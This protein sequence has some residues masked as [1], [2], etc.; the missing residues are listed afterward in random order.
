VAIATN[1]LL[2]YRLPSALASPDAAH[3]GKRLSGFVQHHL[4]H[5]AA[6]GGQ[7]LADVI[8]VHRP[9]AWH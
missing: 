3:D 5:D 8:R 2:W 7:Q 9:R 4:E 1:R 6:A